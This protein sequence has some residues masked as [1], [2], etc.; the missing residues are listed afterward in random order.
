MHC[1]AFGKT[2]RNPLGLAAGFD[3]DGVALDEWEN[4]GFGFAEIGTVTPTSQ[5]GNTKPR[6]F[7]L[8]K[9]QALVN[10]LGFNNRGADELAKK[11]ESRRTRL[12]IGVNIGKGM[13]TDIAIAEKDY[14]YCF[15]KLQSFCDYIV[16]NVSSPNT[17]GLRS[18]QNIESLEKILSVVS[19]NLP[20]FVKIS[21][22]E[23]N[24]N[25]VEIAK[26]ASSRRCGIIATNTTSNPEGG[27]S[28]KPLTERADEVC[29]LVR[30]TA[31]EKMEIIGVGGIFTGEDLFARLKA[32][33]NVCQIYTALIYRGPS[34]AA[35]ILEELLDL[36]EKAGLNSIEEIRG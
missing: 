26:L 22:D 13:D 18:L 1:K 20:V 10:R 15:R 30:K 3:K 27:L 5:P 8:P 35:M 4:L 7:R 29:S 11:L 23:R 34:A 32:G 28:G 9:E 19:D 17:P 36:M 31:G 16:V 2:L 14:E 24:E 21:P 12:P 33:A 6:M 25:I